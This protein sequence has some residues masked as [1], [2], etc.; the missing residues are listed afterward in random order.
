MLDYKTLSRRL[1][2]DEYA[3]IYRICSMKDVIGTWDDV[4]KIL[5]E[6]LGYEY[7]ES[8]Y[9]KQYQSFQKILESNSAVARQAAAICS[10]DVDNQIRELRKE[11]MKLQTEKLEYNR[12][13]REM[14]RDE[15]IMDKIIEAIRDIPPLSCPDCIVPDAAVVR[16]NYAGRAATGILCFGDEHYG[17]EFTVRGLHG[18]VLNAYSPDIYEKRMWSLLD[19]VVFKAISAGLS[20]IKVYSFGDELDGILRVSQLSKL[21]YGVVESTV[22]YADF[23]SRWLN[24]LTEY[25]EVEYHMAEGNHTELRQL[26][27]PKGTFVDDNMSRV[28]KEIIRTRLENN[29]RFKLVDNG[30]GNIYDRVYDFTIYGIHGEVKNME[31]ALK[32]F[33]T[34]YD[35]Q[36]DILIGGHKH[37]YA[38]ETVGIGKDIISVPSIVGVDPYSMSIGKTADAGAMFVIV[39]PRKGVTEQHTIKFCEE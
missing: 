15:M 9:R 24:A 14:A 33:S 16:S 18:E 35:T 38:A 25:L 8:K 28:I 36:I 3:Y 32:S 34:M 22:R 27:Q 17:A 39:E 11:R 21:R 1:D 37:H 6:Q 12:W 29:P 23:M 19:Q 10:E 7:T 5:N 2:E 31:N 20:S 26:G 4:G 13:L 30:S